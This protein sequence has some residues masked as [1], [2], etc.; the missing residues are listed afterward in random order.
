MRITVDRD[1][2]ELCQAGWTAIECPHCRRSVH[3]DERITCA[4]ITIAGYEHTLMYHERCIS[5]EGSGTLE[6]AGYDVTSGEG[7]EYIDD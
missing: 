2:G 5:D 4:T 1:T 7:C 3:T 6:E